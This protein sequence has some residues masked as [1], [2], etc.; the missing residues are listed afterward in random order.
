MK[1]TASRIDQIFSTTTA[2]DPE[3]AFFFPNGLSRGA[4]EE[5]LDKLSQAWAI[6]GAS[7]AIDGGRAVFDIPAKLSLPIEHARFGRPDAVDSASF[8]T[9]LR[10]Q[11]SKLGEAPLVRIKVSDVDGGT[12]LCVRF[13]HVLGDGYSLGL[14]IH[15][16]AAVNRGLTVP[17]PVHVRGVLNVEASPWT[18]P[19]QFTQLTGL[20]VAEGKSRAWTGGEVAWN[21]HRW[22]QKDFQAALEREAANAGVQLFPNEWLCGYFL[23]E[24]LRKAGKDCQLGVPIDFRRF[25]RDVGFQYL[26]NAIGFASIQ[27]AYQETLPTVGF[28]GTA[29]GQAI[30]KARGEWI[31]SYLAALESLFVQYGPEA[32]SLIP[33]FDGDSRVLVTNL[34]RLPM[35][36]YDF[37]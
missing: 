12:W 6:L 36:Q 34:S 30:R 19:E 31:P 33:L 3:L 7:W 17:D 15:S 4:L 11:L 28:V 8:L 1:L 26:G 22:T 20:R 10:P 29:I 14:F 18:N 37:G 2:L 27:V 16:W 9:A 35:A 24:H 23:T 5:G 21:F 13:S 25:R 32:A